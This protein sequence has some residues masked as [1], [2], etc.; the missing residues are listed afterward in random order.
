MN[1]FPSPSPLFS[2]RLHMSLEHGCYF[3]VGSLIKLLAAHHWLYSSILDVSI[4]VLYCHGLGPKILF[5]ELMK[6]MSD[7][8]LYYKNN[9]MHLQMVTTHRYTHP[10]L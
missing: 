3:C 10:A 9:A 5:N 1:R 8:S 2:G 7:L 4:F 6:D